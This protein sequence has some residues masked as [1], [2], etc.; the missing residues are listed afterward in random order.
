V[1]KEMGLRNYARASNEDALSLVELL[2]PEELE[3]LYIG[4]S[5]AGVAKWKQW[6]KNHQ[7]D[8]LDF[9]AATPAARNKKKQW[10][11]PR[12]RPLLILAAIRHCLAAEKLLYFFSDN[13][14]L[15]APGGPYRGTTAIAG[16][17]FFE[18][19]DTSVPDWPE[20]LNYPSPFD[21][22]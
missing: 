20:C 15:L 13:E 4:L 1:K 5:K 22:H 3:T 10:N 17:L 14:P 2:T 16:T 6:Q 18:L 7:G 9:V 12:L 21:E 11:D 19:T 8:I